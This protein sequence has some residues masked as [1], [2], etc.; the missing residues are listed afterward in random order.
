M[1]ATGRDQISYI[2]INQ[3]SASSTDIL[4]ELHNEVWEGGKLPR[5]WKEAVVIPI[6]K[7]GKNCTKPENYKP[8]ALKSNISDTYIQISEWV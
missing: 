3:L 5:S 2:M 6:R 4:L 7:P 1:S 8:L